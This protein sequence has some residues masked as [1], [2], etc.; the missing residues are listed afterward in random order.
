[1]GYGFFNDQDTDWDGHLRGG[2]IVPVFSSASNEYRY[3]APDS[4]APELCL[5]DSGGPIKMIYG[6]WLTFGIASHLGTTGS[7]C[8]PTAFWAP[9]SAN[10]SWIKSVIGPSNCAETPTNVTC[11]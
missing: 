6:G 10:W 3:D 8:S 5:G 11:W 2:K 4:S 7:K 9:T 1:M